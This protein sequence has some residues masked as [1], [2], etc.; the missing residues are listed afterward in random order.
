MFILLLLVTMCLCITVVDILFLIP[1][2]RT[3]SKVINSSG[4]LTATNIQSLTDIV[5]TI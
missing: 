3:K 4:N 1:F 5:R 2:I